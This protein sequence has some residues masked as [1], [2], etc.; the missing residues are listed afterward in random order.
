MRKA[1]VKIGATYMAKVSGRV[2]PVR[3][4]E[5]SRYGGWVATNL[6]TQHA[7][8]IKTAARLRREVV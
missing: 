3:I 7:V 4:N 2:V 6:A 1:D 8:R 5:E